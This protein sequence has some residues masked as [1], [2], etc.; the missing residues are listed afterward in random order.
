LPLAIGLFR[1]RA[2]AANLR[3]AGEEAMHK[4]MLMV[5]A[6]ISITVTGAF[7]AERPTGS[8]I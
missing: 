7:S 5:A 1:S 3:K 2:R 6:L 8:G 4:A